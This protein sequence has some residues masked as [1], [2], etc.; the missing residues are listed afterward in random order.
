MRIFRLARAPLLMENASTPAMASPIA[1]IGMSGAFPQAPD[2]QSFWRN[3]LEGKDCIGE[4]PLSRWNGQTSLGSPASAGNAT[5]I[6][7]AG[8]IEDVE[9]FDPLFFGISPREAEQMDPQ[10][11]LLMMY[12]CKAIED[13]GYSASSLSGGNTALFVGTINSGYSERLSQAGMT[14]EGYSST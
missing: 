5:N 8:I 7:W 14:I 6:K 9:L 11:R 2:V 1:I 10:Q 3:L 13:A 12:V 4:I